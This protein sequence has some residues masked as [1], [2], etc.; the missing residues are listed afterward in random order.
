ME[1]AFT[2][3]EIGADDEKIV[4]LVTPLLADPDDNTCFYAGRLCAQADPQ[5]ARNQVSALIPKLAA[6][7]VA[8]ERS[9]LHAV[10]GLAPEAQA[11]IPGLGWLLGK[12]DR[13]TALG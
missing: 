5:E 12:P 9:A 3:F 1:V 4:R 6:D 8:G 11:A 7:K 10:W 2:L 13:K